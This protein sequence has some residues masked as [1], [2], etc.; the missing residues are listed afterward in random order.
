MLSPS[1]LVDM[2]SWGGRWLCVERVSDGCP[3]RK[4]QALVG[5]LQQPPA[6]LLP[7]ICTPSAA[8]FPARDADLS[9]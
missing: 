7:Q 8:L 2:V 3:L 4:H 5:G 9:G 1:Y 6:P